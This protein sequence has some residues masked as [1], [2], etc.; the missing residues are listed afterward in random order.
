MHNGIYVINVDRATG[1][2]TMRTSVAFTARFLHACGITDKYIV[3]F[4][5]RYELPMHTRTLAYTH[6]HINTH[7]MHFRFSAHPACSATGL[8]TQAYAPG[9]S[10]L[11]YTAPA[12]P[13]NAFDVA[14][15]A[16]TFGMCST[17][18]CA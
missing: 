5:G 16:S 6:A 4:G 10:Y 3:M 17:F 9:M 7:V 18:L 2:P 8:Q 13:G 14:T 12:L 15:G 11:D 1:F